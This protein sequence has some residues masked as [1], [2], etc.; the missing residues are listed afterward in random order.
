MRL[1][2]ETPDTWAIVLKFRLSSVAL[3]FS[4]WEVLSLCALVKSKH[5]NRILHRVIRISHP[6]ISTFSL[7]HVF[8]SGTTKDSSAHHQKPHWWRRPPP[9]LN[10][11][12]SVLFIGLLLS[13]IFGR[14]ENSS[15]EE[16]VK[17]VRLL[18]KRRVP[19]GTSELPHSKTCSELRQKFSEAK[20]VGD[21]H[22]V[23]LALW[24]Y[25]KAMIVSVESSL[26]PVLLSWAL[27]KH[28]LKRKVIVD[29]RYHLHYDLR[30][31]QYAQVVS[32]EDSTAIQQLGSHYRQSFGGFGIQWRNLDGE[33]EK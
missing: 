31:T 32:A 27:E 10:F 8:S 18:F 30:N 24:V 14:L 6:I 5:S 11:K 33:I 12:C 9:N 1:Q 23:W 29:G 4:T 25:E 26:N 3:L 7:L 21:H 2:L 13:V 15:N 22:G 28:L 20:L 17:R 19:R 16:L